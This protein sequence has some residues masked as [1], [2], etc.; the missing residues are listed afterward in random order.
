MKHDFKLIDQMYLRI[1]SESI[2]SLRLR[3]REIY[4]AAHDL[5]D[6]IHNIP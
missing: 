6:A 1:L 4:P 5:L 3:L 2:M